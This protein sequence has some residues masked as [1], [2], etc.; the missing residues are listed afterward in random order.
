MFFK[1]FASK[2]QLPGLSISGTL[3]ENGLKSD[4]DSGCILL[5]INLIPIGEILT[6]TFPVWVFYVIEKVCVLKSQQSGCSHQV[7]DEKKEYCFHWNYVRYKNYVD[8]TFMNLQHICAM[9][10][11]SKAFLHTWLIKVYLFYQWSESLLST[12]FACKIS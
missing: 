9:A 8:S 11:L 3:V 5:N 7:C 10:P 6:K 1:K 12:P 4:M 2:N